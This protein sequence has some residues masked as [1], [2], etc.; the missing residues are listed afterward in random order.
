[1]SGS[2]GGSGGSYGGS[3]PTT[4]DYGASNFGDTASYAPVASANETYLD[5]YAAAASG[6]YGGSVDNNSKSGTT[7]SAPDTSYAGYAYSGYSQDNGKGSSGNSGQG[8]QS[9]GGGGGGSGKSGGG[10]SSGATQALSALSSALSKFGSA[11]AQ[12]VNPSRVVTSGQGNRTLAANKTGSSG[13]PFDSTTTAFIVIGIAI[14]ALFLIM[15]G[16]E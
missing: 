5:P 13:F 14:L 1:M 9:Q 3:A 2:A 10:G 15:S 12:S 7:E 8:S 6:Q 16:K 4:T 11:I